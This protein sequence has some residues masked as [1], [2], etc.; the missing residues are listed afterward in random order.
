MILQRFETEMAFGPATLPEAIVETARQ[1]PGQVILQDLSLQK[2]TY[3]RLLVGADLLAAQWQALLAEA[4][5]RVGVLLPNVN[6]MPV[7]T[8]SLWAAGKV[9]AILNYSSGTAVLLACARLAGL[10]HIITSKAFIQR[11]KL[12]LGPLTE[13]GIQIALPRRRARPDHPRP[14]YPRPPPPVFEA[15]SINSQ[16]FTIN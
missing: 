3:R 5:Q 4:G 1:R 13:A 8:L 11:A 6:A 16:L 7:A 9:P 10:K 14:A 2:L 12:D 15:P